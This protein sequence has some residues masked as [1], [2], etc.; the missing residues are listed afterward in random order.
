MCRRPAASPHH[1]FVRQAGRTFAWLAGGR[2]LLSEGTKRTIKGRADVQCRYHQSLRRAEKT[3]SPSQSI[4]SRVTATAYEVLPK[5]GLAFLVDVQETTWAITRNME[6]PGLDSL[7]SGQ[8]V[9]LTL[10]HHP[11]FSVV[12][13]YEPQN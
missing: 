8:R 6:G 12:R 10:H 13:A 2:R 11:G 7:R 1:G 9:Q 3:M 5:F 4:R